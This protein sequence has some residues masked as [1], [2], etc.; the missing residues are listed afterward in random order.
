VGNFQ[1]L[2][3]F[4]PDLTLLKKMNRIWK[5]SKHCAFCLYGNQE[6]LERD[7]I[8]N[9]RVFI[10]GFVKIIKLP[11]PD[12]PSL[13]RGVKTQFRIRGKRIE[14]S[15]VRHA[16]ICCSQHPYYI[17]LLTWHALLL[18]K[19]NCT[20]RE[21]DHAL[22]QLIDHYRVYY[23]QKA[24][25]LTRFQLNFLKAYLSEWS[26]LCSREALGKYDLR[27]S[28]HVARIKESLGRKEIFYLL[29]GEIYLM[30]PLFCHWLK[31]DYF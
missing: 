6:Q 3:R 5:E 31:R 23:R 13:I 16:I 24:E 15:A 17:R 8:H 10:K 11:L 1:I 28:S 19:R 25:S 30:D 4:D 18:T 27:S 14:E 2:L 29:N 12:T 22:T 26:R 7:L 20:S 9:G 21:I